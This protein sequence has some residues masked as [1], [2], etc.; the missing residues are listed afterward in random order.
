[1][2]EYFFH[3]I[4]N[5]AFA[6]LSV[7][8]RDGQ[9]CICVYEPVNN[10]LGASI[11]L[12]SG[13][14]TNLSI[15]EMARF[16]TDQNEVSYRKDFVVFW[17]DTI[18]A[19]LSAY[20]D[21]VGVDSAFLWQALNQSFK[22]KQIQTGF[23]IQLHQDSISADTE[24]A[25]LKSSA[26]PV[27]SNI[28][29][30]VSVLVNNPNRLLVGRL[31]FVLGLT[32]VVLVL[33]VLSFLVLFRLINRQKKITQLKDDFIDNV[34]H[35]L[36]TP[37][38]TLKLA[39]ESIDQADTEGDSKSLFEICAQQSNRISDLVDHV[40]KASFANQNEVIFNRE[41]IRPKQLLE[42]IA[43]YYQFTAP[44][45]CQFSF[46]MEDTG[47]VISDRHHLNNIFHN[48]IG[49]AIK[50]GPEEG[51]H[52]RIEGQKQGG[53]FQIFVA[54][55][56]Q[57]I[58][59]QYQKNIFDKFFRVPTGDRH[60]VKGLGLG[61]YYAKTILGQLSGDIQLLNSSTSG[62]TFSITIPLA[63]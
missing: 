24:H 36:L 7:C 6:K 25:Q 32:L 22:E 41:S 63:D 54:D 52:V 5:P 37:V 33:I 56:G 59:A 27:V 1:M 57:G 47:C 55:N 30:W 42:E 11:A 29:K 13:T 62:T 34:T 39:L 18:A 53:H 51:V 8:D 4:Q 12:K 15:P 31:G 40:L 45:P 35:E 20:Q 46:E 43:A 10:E 14:D 21:T 16:V 28:H 2:S 17:T 48:V 9:P 49:N 60:E 38:T 19:R 61:L 26:V 23:S 44:K 50:Y 58:P 3:D